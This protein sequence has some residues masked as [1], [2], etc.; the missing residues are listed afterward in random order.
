M[1]MY[2]SKPLIKDDPKNG[3]DETRGQGIKV[4]QRLGIF[5]VTFVTRLT[6]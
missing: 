2:G 4:K 1:P 6:A 5:N 3:T